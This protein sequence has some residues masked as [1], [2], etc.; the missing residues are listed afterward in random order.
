MADAL[1]RA[2]L[3]CDE[4]S[5]PTGCF[6]SN[7]NAVLTPTVDYKQLATD[8]TT[9]EEILNYQT[10]CTNLELRDVPF[11]N[12]KFNVLCDIS[13]GKPCPIVPTEW[14]KTIFDD[15]HGLAHTGT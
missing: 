7:I 2:P 12:G 1:S 13:T 11:E 5:I 10:A 9:S 15:V 4:T 8:Q 14:R 6:Y 3:T